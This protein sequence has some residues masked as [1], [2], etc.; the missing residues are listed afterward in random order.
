MML[1]TMLHKE[2][3]FVTLT[4]SDDSI[5]KCPDGQTTLDPNDL[6]NWL[7]RLRRAYEPARFRFFAVGEY[8]DQSQ[9]PHYHAILYG[10]P[11]CKRG[12]TGLAMGFHVSQDPAPECCEPC[13]RLSASWSVGGQSLGR[14]FQGS[15]T[16]ESCQ[17][18]A[19]Y[20]V[21]KLSRSDDERLKGRHP[22]FARMSLR[23]GIG[24]GAMQNV[25]A[26]LVQNANHAEQSDVPT[27]LT[28]G[29]KNLPLGRY[30][31]TKL[32]E[33]LGKETDPL[34]F[35]KMGEKVQHLRERARSGVK[36]LAQLVV[37]ENAPKNA[38]LDAK[39]AIYERKKH[40]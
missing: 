10:L 9:R 15:V 36:T 18:V 4:Y 34:A 2:N 25:A 33:T 16:T 37:E 21:K 1:E 22:E 28:H 26:A 31:R 13:A 35:Y 3:T 30:L 8:G 6:R 11:S 38:A 14:V 40:L 12:R 29:R 32:R 7:K 23:P 24:A 17:Y 5:P 39:L 27:S 20:T 19:G